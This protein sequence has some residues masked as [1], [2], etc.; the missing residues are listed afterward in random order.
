MMMIAGIV[1]IGIVA[2]LSL[3]TIGQ[4]DRKASLAEWGQDYCEKM[5]WQFLDETVALKSIR[6]RRNRY[7]WALVRCYAFE[8]SPDGIRRL[9]G[10]M[11]TRRPWQ[12]PLIRTGDQPLTRSASHEKDTG[13]ADVIH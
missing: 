1:G 7:G 6:V 3:A 13:P 5:G 10:E 2:V 9:K 8:Y 11:I 4:S 12:A